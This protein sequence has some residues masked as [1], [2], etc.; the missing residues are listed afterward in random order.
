MGRQ[1]LDK[2]ASGEVCADA[3][4]VGIRHQLPLDGF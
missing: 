3:V 1:V 2:N 4:D